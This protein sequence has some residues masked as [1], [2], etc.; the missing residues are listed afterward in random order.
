[1]GFACHLACETIFLNP[2][3]PAFAELEG[4]DGVIGVG[5]LVGGGSFGD[6]RGGPRCRLSE[7]GFARP[8]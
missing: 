8:I 4:V 7:I 5:L 3:E 2:P 1:M 6:L